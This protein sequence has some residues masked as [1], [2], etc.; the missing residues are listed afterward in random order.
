M[1]DPKQLNSETIDLFD[2]FETLWDEKLVLAIFT[3]IA[4]AIGGV[5]VSITKPS[6][7]TTAKY[8]AYQ[9]PPFAVEEHLPKILARTFY[10]ADIFSRWKAVAP[11]TSLVFDMINETMTIDGVV[12]KLGSEV[13]LVSFREN[14]TDGETYI[15]IRSDDAH[16]IDEV[17]NYFQ[18]VSM[19]LSKE[20]VSQAQRDKSRIEKLES[21][22][23]KFE[24]ENILDLSKE[25]LAIED[26][27]ENVAERSQLILISRPLPPVNTGKSNTLILI[28]ALFVG[29][30][31]GAMF[32]IV[33]KAYRAR[34]LML[35]NM[36]SQT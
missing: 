31:T 27:L 35:A 28:I 11:N 21:R 20:Y 36:N 32:S 23:G 10:N 29:G 9:L 16:L 8:Q 19:S 15:E 18:F 33:R 17:L 2:L 5:Y 25:K 12:F 13:G 26:Y 30:T 7:L 1:V 34:K 24:S 6:Y 22:L 4:V 14:K 3:V